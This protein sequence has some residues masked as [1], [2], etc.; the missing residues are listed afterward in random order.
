MPT[1]SGSV[2]FDR[3]RDVNIGGNGTPL[4]GV[5]VALQE[6]TTLMRLVVL[7]DA[8]GGFSFL[9]VP[10]GAYRLVEAY[11]LSG[12]VSTPGDFSAAAVAPEALAALPPPAAIPSPPPGMTAVDCVSPSTI[13][14][15]VAA[16]D[17]TGQ[18]FFNG[19]VAYAPLSAVLD[20]CAVVMPINLILDASGGTFGGFPAG[21]AA[22]SAPIVNPYPDISPDFDYV[23]P[24]PATYTPTDGQFTLQNTMNNALSAS[25]GA[26]WRIS[27]HT[28]GN[29]TGRM[30]IVNEDDP[31][32]IIFR[33]QAAVAP[34]TTY[35]FSTW[36]LNLFRVEGY[37]GPEF[38][39]RIL[40]GDEAVLY[41][42]PL[43]GEIPVNEAMP[44]WKEIGSV[45][46]SGVASHFIIEF[47]SQGEAA[48]GNDFALDDISLREIV[49]PSFALRKTESR[50]SAR[51][52]ETLTYEV[53]LHN[54]CQQPLT[55]IYFFDH[56]PQGLEVVPD[57][58][59][60]NGLS[61]PGL[62]PLVGF[63]APDVPGGATLR[64]A[65]EVTVAAMPTV[66]PAVNTASLRY[67]YTPVP[68]G[69]AEAY[70]LTSNPVSLLVHREGS[71]CPAGC[72]PWRG[73]PCC[74][75]WQGPMGPCC[76]YNPVPVGPCCNGWPGCG[77]ER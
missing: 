2:V 74:N 15:T 34:H 17:V 12:G 71:I 21:T 5:P 73:G 30:M 11:C 60:I 44:Q 52:G 1:V 39:V 7:T 75:P 3:D 48:I 43:G 54:F 16:A 18:Y 9:N 36:I 56:I 28:T 57:S 49:L 23:L 29:E 53:T 55:G 25:I 67:T 40:D 69:I 22:N 8:A 77:R 14:I 42:S 10:A 68:G 63:S 6:T 66:N 64:I 76:G 26:W 59:T 38:A 45:I 19:P 20:P 24:N 35:L 51:I 62:S 50:T 46:K 47:F 65:F 72:C 33:T 13:L 27:D 32:G 4:S 31:G 70:A 61:M 41:E 37:P 58:V